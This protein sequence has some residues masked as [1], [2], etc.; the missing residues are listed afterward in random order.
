MLQYSIEKLFLIPVDNF[1]AAGS[2]E[3]KIPTIFGPHGR[4]VGI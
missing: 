3:K 2:H 4:F 1:V